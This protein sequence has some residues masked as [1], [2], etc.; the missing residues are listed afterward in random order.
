MHAAV[1]LASRAACPCSSVPHCTPLRR[2]CHPSSRSTDRDRLAVRLGGCTLDATPAA[3]YW[4][5]GPATTHSAVARDRIGSS[6]TTRW[7][8]TRTWTGKRALF[9]DADGRVRRRRSA[10]PRCR[11]GSRCRVRIS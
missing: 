10:L 7:V 5:A 2:P 4:T 8:R 1:T 9:C 6:S 11:R 3:T